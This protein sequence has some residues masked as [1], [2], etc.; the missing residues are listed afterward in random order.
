MGDAGLG[1]WRLDIWPKR[2]SGVAKDKQLGNR[3]GE[4]LL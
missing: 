4:R 3:S 1:K 2:P